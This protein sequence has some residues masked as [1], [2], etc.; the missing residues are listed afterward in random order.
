MKGRSRSGPLFFLFACLLLLL[1]CAPNILRAA[2]TAVVEEVYDGDTLR[3]RIGGGTEIVRLIGID[4]PER[5]HPTKEKEYYGDEAAAHLSSL[6]LGKTVRLERGEEETDRYYRLLRYVYLPPPDNRLLNLEMIHAGMA[7]AYTRFPFSR[8]DEFVAAEAKAVRDAKGLWKDGGAAEARW[9]VAGNSRSV[10]VYPA[11]GGK[12]IIFHKNWFIGEV[13]R[14]DLAKEIEWLLAARA[15]LSETEFSQRAIKRGYRPLDASAPSPA[16]S[17]RA[18]DA[19]PFNTTEPISW[20]EA[21]QHVNKRI[22]IEGTIVRTYRTATM[23]YLNFHANWKRYLTLVIHE[24]DIHLF[25]ADPE[26]HFKGKTVRARGEI[27]RHKG[28]LEMTLRDPADLV[29]TQ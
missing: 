7:R 19:A 20:E 13:Q 9:L 3:V 15:E 6:C 21:N 27:V 16:T 11:G 17:T 4:A 12:Y 5:G 28:R 29:I 8:Q 24:K 14:K 25:P 26:N 1:A 2:E 23:L 22:L 10:N 18:P